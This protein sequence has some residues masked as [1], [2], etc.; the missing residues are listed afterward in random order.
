M[1]QP[2]DIK[3]RWLCHSICVTGI[4]VTGISFHFYLSNS[5]H[6][7]IIIDDECLIHF[8]SKSNSKRRYMKMALRRPQF[9]SRT[10]K[11]QTCLK[12]VDPS[13]SDSSF[14]QQPPVFLSVLASMSSLS[15]SLKTSLPTPIS[16]LSTSLP[17]PLPTSMSRP[18]LTLST[19]STRHGLKSALSDFA[20]PTF[21]NSPQQE[22]PTKRNNHST[23]RYNV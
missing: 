7:V 4:C 2:R 8:P 12:G 9:L 17:T 5:K 16:S 11:F 14:N 19:L 20:S 22:T 1:F 23:S 13:S 3:G 18:F 15:T 6:T 21:L 10:P